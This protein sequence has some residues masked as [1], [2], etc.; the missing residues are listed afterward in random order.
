MVEKL[1]NQ[2]FCEFFLIKN[3]NNNFWFGSKRADAPCCC[4]SFNMFYM[5][6]DVKKP[7]VAR[8]SW[9]KV[10]ENAGQGKRECG[11]KEN[12]NNSLTS[13]IYS[14]LTNF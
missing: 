3:N 6:S 2:C 1:S 5:F 4:F 9:V 7:Y 14:L 13:E 10:R 11:S 8:V 12:K